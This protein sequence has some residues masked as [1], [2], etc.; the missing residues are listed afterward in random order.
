MRIAI[1]LVFVGLALARLDPNQECFR[2][3]IK[4]ASSPIFN[5]TYSGLRSNQQLIA[6]RQIATLGKTLSLICKPLVT[7]LSD[8]PDG[9][10]YS[11]DAL[12]FL[13]YITLSAADLQGKLVEAQRRA[14]KDIGSQFTEIEQSIQ[15]RLLLL[16]ECLNVGLVKHYKDPKLTQDCLSRIQVVDKT[17]TIGSTGLK[18]ISLGFETYKVCSA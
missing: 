15:R 9:K 16:G 18:L 5:A 12:K 17:H 7:L 10:K 11:E 8:T 3:L 2:G 6:A 14:K 13:N 4:L 1:V